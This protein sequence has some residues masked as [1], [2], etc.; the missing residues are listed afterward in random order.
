MKVKKQAP[1]CLNVIWTKESLNQTFRLPTVLPEIN[2][3]KQQSFLQNVT[4]L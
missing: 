1:Y 3:I 2:R 4:D